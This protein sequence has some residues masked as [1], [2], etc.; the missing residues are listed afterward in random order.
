M[1]VRLRD[2]QKEGYLRAG[3]WPINDRIDEA[4]CAKYHCSTSLRPMIGTRAPLRDNQ[5]SYR[6]TCAAD[7]PRNVQRN[8]GRAMKHRTLG[9]S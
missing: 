1:C 8:E 5:R 4:Y 6:A 7:W 9:P 3:R 2:L